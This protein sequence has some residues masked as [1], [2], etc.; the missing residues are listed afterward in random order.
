MAAPHPKHANPPSARVRIEELDEATIRFAGD[1]SD[2]MQLVGAQ[3]TT[4][5]AMYGNHVCTLPDQ[6]AEIRAPAGAL[7]GV[8]GFQVHFSRHAIHTPGDSLNVLIAMNPASLKVNLI[9][10]ETNGLLIANADA[11]TPDEW[12]KAGYTANPLHDGSLTNYRVLA[13]PMSEL[14]RDAVV[15][16]KLSPREAERCKSFF[17]LGLALWLFDRPLEPTLKWIRDIYV[18]NPAMIEAN[19]RTLNAG[20]HYGETCPQLAVRYRVAKAAIPAGKYRKIT[21]AEALAL[22]ILAAAEQSKLPLVFSCFPVTP[23][24]EVLHLLCEWKQPNVKIVQA[25]DDLAALNLALGAAFG[26]ALGVT[27]TT[28]PG[29]SL[30]SEALGLAVMSE[31]P[32]VILDIQRAGPSTGMPTKTEQADLLQ[33]LHGRHG[34]CPLIVLAAATP[35]DCFAIMLEAVRLAIR[36]MT[37]VIVLSDVCLANGAEPW[38]VPVLAELPTFEAHHAT[39]RIDSNVVAA[40]PAYQRDDRLVRPWAIPGTAGLEHRTGGLE[41]EDQTG[42]VSYDPLNHQKMVQTRAMKVARAADEIPL[43]SVSG[44]ASG[45]LLV[46]SWGSTYGAVADAVARLHRKGLPVAHAHLRHLHPLPTNTGDVVKRYRQVLVPELNTGQLC[47]V[48]RAAFL[49]DAVSLSKVQGLAFTVREIERKIEEMLN[50]H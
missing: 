31:L 48:V 36:C 47:Q 6:A 45:D 5:S 44:P 4:A 10:L 23:A 46:L 42:N 40:Y 18:K 17:A 33:A 20:Y 35:A 49:V 38:R 25:E 50:D 1:V 11:F 28:G 41:K 27:A 32:C 21:G 34:E 26:G 3:F 39:P 15:R 8:S 19:T 37:P 30:Q 14:N 24:N 16:V 9:D 43:L 13:V 7:A 29:L 22:G 2:G 12:E